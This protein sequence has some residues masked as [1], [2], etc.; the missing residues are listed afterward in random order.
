LR[1]GSYAQDTKS[2]LEAEPEDCDRLS[3]VS[4]HQLF[5]SFLGS[6]VPLSARCRQPIFLIQQ[7]SNDGDREEGCKIIG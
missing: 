5:P 6:M 4:C 1:A 2:D 3:A 7:H